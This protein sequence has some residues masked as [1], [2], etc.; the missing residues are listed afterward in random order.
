LE[1]IPEGVV[2][3]AEVRAAWIGACSRCVDP[4][5]GEARV[6]VDELFEPEPLAGETYRLGDDE[7]D[8]EP[9][10]RDAILLELPLAPRCR[11]E[12]AG[13]CPRCGADRNRTGCDCRVETDDPRWA[14][15]RSLEL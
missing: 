12:C 1:R 2:V 6:H 14:A 11:A 10:V 8:L 13:L 7:I 9:L 3:R 5:S 15:L 4:V